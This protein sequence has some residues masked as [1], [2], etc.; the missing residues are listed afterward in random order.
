MS[1]RQRLAFASKQETRIV[2]DA[3]QLRENVTG[4][5][6][7]A[8]RRDGVGLEAVILRLGRQRQQ[9]DAGGD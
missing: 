3:L 5:E 7:L 1:R 6:I 8:H 9:R 4:N 2:H